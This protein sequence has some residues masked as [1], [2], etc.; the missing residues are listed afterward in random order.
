MT[1]KILEKCLNCFTLFKQ[2]LM[3]RENVELIEETPE[4]KIATQ[5][6][7]SDDCLRVYNIKILH[8]FGPE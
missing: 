2:H 7:F 8:L 1:M 5:S 3:I 6:S 4:A